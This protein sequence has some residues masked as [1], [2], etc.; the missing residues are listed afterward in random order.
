MKS[1]F[2]VCV[3]FT[4][5]AGSTFIIGCDHNTYKDISSSDTVVSSQSDTI[6]DIV[7]STPPNNNTVSST[8]VFSEHL[9]EITDGVF[10]STDGIYQIIIPQNINLIT[11]TDTTAVFSSDDENTNITI[12]SETNNG[13]YEDLSQQTLEAI[14]Q[15]LYTEITVTDFSITAD[16]DKQ[17]VCRLSFTGLHNGATTQV[18]VYKA[19]TEKRVITIQIS[20]SPDKENTANLLDIMS[21]SLIFS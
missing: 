20:A 18:Y 5:V 16:S 4:L 1:K 14:Y 7:N 11:A 2:I 8:P 17:T 12:L 9:G 21:Q 19:I 6:P 13:Q 10:T 3:L 15:Q